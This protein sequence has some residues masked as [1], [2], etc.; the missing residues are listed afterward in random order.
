[1]AKRIYFA[2]HYQDVIDFR[3]NVVRKH[4]FTGGVKA[5]GYYDHSIWEESKKRGDIALK[6]MINGELEGTSLTAILIGSL[7]YARRWVR[8][9]IMKSIERGN[10]VIGI[11]INSI[12]GKDQMIK[13]LGPNPFDYL[14]LWISDDGCKGTPIVWDGN[15]WVI[16][17]DLE[18]FAID[19]Q[20]YENCG[21]SFQL[22]HWLPV[23]DWVAGN[24]FNNF[25]SWIR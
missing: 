14:G 17:S 22:S 5:A 16:Y 10:R 7:T 11:H 20:S 2:F 8:Y 13:A 25:S 9:E 1:M 21:R 15:Q 4:N 23:Y 19:K 3:A 24:G 12:K 18:G 6:R